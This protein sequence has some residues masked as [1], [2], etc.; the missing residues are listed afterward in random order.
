MVQWWSGGKDSAWALDTLSADSGWLVDGLVGQVDGRSGRSAV[1]GVRKEL[2]EQQAIA[3]GLPLQLVEFDQEGKAREYAADLQRGLGVLRRAGTEFL[4]FGELRS[5]AYRSWRSTQLVS[6]GLAA[7]FPLW[8]RDSRE[9][10]EMMLDAGLSAWVCAVD[11][12]RMPTNLLG[13]RF[14]SEFLDSLP[15]HVDP[16]GENDEFHTFVEYAPGW[17]NRVSVEPGDIVEK[18]GFAFVDLRPSIATVVVERH[19]DEGSLG[20]QNDERATSVNAFDRYERL[21]RVRSY[22]DEHLGDDLSMT[23]VATVAAMR[24][25]SF[26][27]YFRQHVGVNFGKWMAQRRVAR[28]CELLRY[29]DSAVRVIGKVV[30]F[31]SGRTFRQVFRRHC[32]CS[33]SK[34]RKIF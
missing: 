32:G 24:P 21:R 29:S 5:D 13:R 20:R 17:R 22:V 26:G 34:Y 7:E 33:P 9:H 31:K 19:F 15:M 6:T 3:V 1:H 4:S 23:D 11:T 8:G 18:Y 28:A 12:L 27:R 25:S 14:D 30:G 10:A 2:L 16:A